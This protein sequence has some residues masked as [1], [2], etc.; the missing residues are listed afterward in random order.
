ME[1]NRARRAH[2][3]KMALDIEQIEQ[4]RKGSKGLDAIYL[5]SPESYVVDCLISDI[6]RQKYRRT[7]LIWTSRMTMYSQ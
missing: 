2:D 6:E 3:A 4:K 7:F 5:L 1:E